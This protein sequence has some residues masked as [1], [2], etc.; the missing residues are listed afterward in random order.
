MTASSVP[1]PKIAL[2]NRNRYTFLQKSIHGNQ[3]ITGMLAGTMTHD[4]GYGFLRIGRNLERADMTTRIIDV[5]SASLLPDLEH[6]QSAFDNIQWMSVL[7]SLSAYQMYRREMRLRISRPD[8]LKFLLQEDLF[9][10]ALCHTLQQIKQC[11]KELP[12]FEKAHKQVDALESQL[13]KAKPQALKQDKLHEFIDD[14]Q[15][16]LSKIHER[17]SETYF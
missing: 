13:L 15:L 17:I 2:V 14:M 4:E 6:E 16:G 12:R 7:K 1:L 3:M 9:P 5:R 8:V 10:R 11:L